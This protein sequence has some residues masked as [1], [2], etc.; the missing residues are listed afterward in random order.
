MVDDPIDV[1]VLLEEPPVLVPVAPAPGHTAADGKV[2][3]TLE[4][5]RVS[6]LWSTLQR[7]LARGDSILTRG[8]LTYRIFA[9]QHRRFLAGLI[10]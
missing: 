6:K 2:T 8:T 5:S 7:T 9:V 3:L 10:Q 4:S 1:P